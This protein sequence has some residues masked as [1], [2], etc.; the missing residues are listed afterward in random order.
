MVVVGSDDN[1][2]FFEF[3]RAGQDRADI[4]DGC[5][6][7]VVL[8]VFAGADG[9]GLGVAVLAIDDKGGFESKCLES[10]NEKVSGPVDPLRAG[11]ASFHL[12]RGEGFDDLHEGRGVQRRAGGIGLA[13][14]SDGQQCEPHQGQAGTDRLT[15]DR[16]L[17]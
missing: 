11:V 12:G 17:L 16:N 5:F 14:T 3:A 8:V 4:V 10:M 1:D 9:E 6:D 7:D 2:L 15:H 13:G